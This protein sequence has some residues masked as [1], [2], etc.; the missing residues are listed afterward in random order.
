MTYVEKCLYDYRANVA[1][2]EMLIEE[3]N[4]LKS[5]HGHSYEIN[6][7]SV[8]AD[9]VASTVNNLMALEKKIARLEKKIKPV[10]ELLENLSGSDLRFQQMKDILKMKYFNHESVRYILKELAISER[11]FRRRI[12]ELLHLAFIFFGK[13]E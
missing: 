11:T 4:N 8:G 3:K 13:G 2:L 10:N 9:P 6:N 5:I 1:A 7:S 12:R